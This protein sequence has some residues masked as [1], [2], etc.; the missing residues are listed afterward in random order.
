[1]D[2]NVFVDKE[3]IF[4]LHKGASCTKYYNAILNFI[5]PHFLN[6]KGGANRVGKT[7]DLVNTIYKE[8][9]DIVNIVKY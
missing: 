6:M 2:T 3:F 7:L 5:T 8:F 4:P 9:V 1:M